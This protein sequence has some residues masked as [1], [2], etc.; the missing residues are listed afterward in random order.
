MIDQNTRTEQP[1]TFDFQSLTE[2][3]SFL[4]QRR[5]NKVN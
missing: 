2:L 4:E 5:I 1:K 3:K